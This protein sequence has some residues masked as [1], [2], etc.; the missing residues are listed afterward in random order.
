ML[1]ASI[2]QHGPVEVALDELDPWI[3]LATDG[4]VVPLL[5]VAARADHPDRLIAPMAQLRSGHLAVASSAVQIE[6]ALLGV[7]DVLAAASVPFAIIKGVATAHLDC[8]D[9]SW[10]QFGDVDLLVAPADLEHACKQLEAQGWRQEHALPRGH[11]PFTHAI[12]LCSAA[13]V[14]IDVHQRIGH[15]A[16]GILVPTEALLADRVP[17]TIAGRSMWA[18]SDIDRLIHASVHMVSSRGPYRRLSSI[19]DVLLMSYLQQDSADQVLDR[20]DGWLVGTLVR[21]A[22]IDAWGAAMLPV[23]DRWVVANAASPAPRSRLVD[24]A[25]L[26]TRRRPIV[27]ELAHLRYLTGMR[28]RL[29]YLR[30][31]VM[32]GADY[33]AAKGRH[34]ARAQLRYLADRARSR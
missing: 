11:R 13:R 3:A 29:A 19:A 34:D 9:P 7:V 20:A 10:R 23:P 33:R 31:H 22:V 24:A 21:R 18:L 28:R 16:L 5:H 30:G 8:P 32:P 27:E 26:A 6:H 2:G 12:T 4:R 1:R 15:R 14:E 25:Y 17:F